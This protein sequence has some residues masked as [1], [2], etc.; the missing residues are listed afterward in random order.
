[1]RQAD[2]LEQVAVD[3]VQAAVAVALVLSAGLLVAAQVL[4]PLA[5][6]QRHCAPQPLVRV[7][8]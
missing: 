2:E 3:A 6:R 5:V 1:M 8:G 4:R 7:W